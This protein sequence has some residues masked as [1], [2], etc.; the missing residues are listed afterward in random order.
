VFLDP[1]TNKTFSIYKQN[2]EYRRGRGNGWFLL[3]VS[4]DD[5]GEDKEQMEAF[6]IELACELIGL[7]RQKRGVKVVNRAEEQEDHMDEEE[8]E[9]EE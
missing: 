7:T 6:L 4:A 9:E 3:G 2:M 5:D 8:D 1:D